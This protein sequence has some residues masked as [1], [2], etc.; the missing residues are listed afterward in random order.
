MSFDADLSVDLMGI[1]LKNP[2]VAEAAGYSVSDWGMKRLIKGGCGAV[3]TKSTTWDPLGGYP[4]A[5]EGT[6]QPR[7]YW[8]YD[9]AKHTL[10]GTEALQNPGY[11]KM[12]EFIRNVKPYADQHEAHIIGSLSPRSPEEA[13]TI[14]RE[15][16]KAGASAI[17]MDLICA[18]AGPFRSL[19]YPGRGYE[20]LGRYWSQDAERLIEVIKA[21]KDAIDIP[22]MPKT[23]VERHLP[24][25]E[26]I[27]EG[28][29]KYLDGFAFD[30]HAPAFDIDPYTAKPMY[31]K[32]GGEH[33]RYATFRFTV[34][35][36]QLRTGKALLPSGGIHTAIDVVKLFM[37]GADAGGICTALYR[38]PNVALQICA[39]L[40]DY[41]VRQALDNLQSIK[42]IS[43]RYLP[44]KGFPPIRES[45][46]SQARTLGE[47]YQG[48][49]PGE[50]PVPQELLERNPD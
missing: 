5:W 21:T 36:A 33:I 41:M 14:A 20:K 48:H 45:L 35:M 18:S 34:E 43:L 50:N 37:L 23:L 16:E 4:R 38:D 32:V 13:A 17:H 6:P 42:G 47:K 2:L 25:P 3:I 40:E 12:S 8:V 26:T 30:G 27:V 44:E 39:D 22:L 10:D 49:I 28:Y 7:C 1:R 29:G 15:F 24:R 11:R 19:Q 31:S 9:D 46:L